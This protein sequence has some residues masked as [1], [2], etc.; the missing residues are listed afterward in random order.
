[1]RQTARELAVERSDPLTLDITG[2]TCSSC[3]GRLE[4]LLNDQTE[5]E[6]ATVNFALE[7]ADLKLDTDHMSEATLFSLI[8][9][10]GFQAHLHGQPDQAAE[11]LSSLNKDRI[12]LILSALFTLPLVLQMLVMSLGGHFPLPGYVALTLATPVQFIFGARFYRGAWAALKHGYG[13]MDTLVVMGT[14]AAYF[15]SLYMLITLGDAASDHLYFEASSVIITLVLLGKYLEDRSKRGTTDAIRELMALQPDTARIIQDGSE[16]IRPVEQVKVGDIVKCLPGERISLDGIIIEGQS[17]T[18][19]SLISG[20]SMPLHKNTGDKVVAGS[21]NGPGLL[22]IRVSARRADSSL[23]RIIHLVENAQAGKAPIQKLVDKISGIFVPAVILIAFITLGLWLISGHGFEDGLIAAVS[24]LVI[25]CPCALGLATPAAVMTGTG[26]AAR[27]GIL[28]KDIETLEKAH[29][30]TTLVFDKTGTLTTGKPRVTY[31]QVVESSKENLDENRMLR[32]AASVQKGSE[33]PLAHALIHAAEKRHLPLEEPRNFMSHT[34][35]GISGKVGGHSIVIGQKDFLESLD[36]VVEEQ[37]D[38][39]INAEEQS[40]IWVA[41]DGHFSGLIGVSDPARPEAAEAIQALKKLKIKTMMMSGDAA[42][43]VKNISQQLGIEDW[44]ARMKPEDK[45]H[46][47]ASLQRAGQ[48]VAMTGDG[49]NDAPALAMADVSFAMGSGSDVAMETANIT[50]MRSD[51]R[52]VAAALDIS[53][54]T[55]T[56]IRQNLFWAFFYNLVGIPLAALGALSPE[57]AG[58]AMA[59]SSVSV[60]SNALL[61]KRW[62]APTGEKT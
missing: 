52:M 48:H 40:L 38:P 42:P 33:H 45:A 49:I 58:A 21:I 35:R 25:A 20:E 13:T 29:N 1:M 60:V 26:A 43:V 2:M 47:V 36:I 62:T 61:L 22:K 54:A 19:E 50:L 6:D 4:S 39:H 15:F 46:A 18:D 10:A 7:R 12:R 27:A 32:L 24:V 28:I 51:P 55:W 14:S 57:I 59:L 31:I 11:D 56:K 34:G 23:A 41:I 5:I 53:R 30:V 17:E 3:A 37:A 9:E 44:Q 8:E 16:E